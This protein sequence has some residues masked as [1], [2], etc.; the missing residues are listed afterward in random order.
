MLFVSEFHVFFSGQVLRAGEMCEYGEPHQLLCDPNS[1]L[2][3]LVEHTGPVAAERLKDIAQ[4][5]HMNKMKN[6]LFVH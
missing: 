6:I 5:A 4:T 2:L 3:R 1:Y